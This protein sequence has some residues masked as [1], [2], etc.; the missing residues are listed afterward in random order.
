MAWRKNH[1]KYT[2]FV[3]L[4]YTMLQNNKHTQE[5]VTDRHT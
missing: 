1:L 3:K 2:S 4:Q 5:K